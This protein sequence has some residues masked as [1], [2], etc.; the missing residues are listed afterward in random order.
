MNLELKLLNQLINQ[1]TIQQINNSINQHSINTQGL[2]AQWL[3]PMTFN[4]KVPRLSLSKINVYRL[5]T[6]LL[7]LT[8]FPP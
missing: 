1:S 8:I 2:L 7:K 3:T 4:H 5:A 6:E